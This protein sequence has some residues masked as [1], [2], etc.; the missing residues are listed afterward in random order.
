MTS[1]LC[2]LE[3]MATDRYAQSCG[4]SNG[5]LRAGIDDVGHSGHRP[6]FSP[7]FEISKSAH[8]PAMKR[9]F[10]SSIE[11]LECRIA[12]AILVNGPN[13][14]GSGNP[15]TGEMSL[16]DN[17]V[18]LVKVLAGQII[19]WY[20]DGNIASVS[21]GPG[22]NFQITG[23]VLG[24]IVGNLGADG[25]LSDSDG[26][27][28][29]GEDGNVLLPNDLAGL[30]TTQFATQ[31]GGF[32]YLITGGAAANLNISGQI[33]GIYTGDG[34]FD[35]DSDA[36]VAGSVVSSIGFDVNPLTAGPQ[37]DFTFTKA[38]SQMKAGA[39]LKN[40]VIGIGKELEVFTGSGN[41]GRAVPDPLKPGAPGGDIV[42]IT[43]KSAFLDA[44]SNGSTPSYQLKAGSGGDGKTGGKGGDIAT[45][46]EESS[47]GSV[48]FTAGNGGGGSGGKGGDGGSLRLLE[49]RSDSTRYEFHAGNGGD[50]APAGAGGSL[51]TSN[52]TN[53][54]T[55]GGII[56]TADFTG[57][58]VDDLLIVDTA[59]GNMVIMKND[60]CCLKSK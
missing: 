46:I 19:V 26:D 17:S 51:A 60:A 54:T 41:P 47:V 20:Q 49:M 6:C 32:R 5:F 23:D 30:K 50:G 9:P 11:T 2:G 10:R 59:T 34:V 18:T 29:N 12:P 33:E 4:L 28:V 39:G 24:D 40:A 43:I 37:D 44:N 55:T 13:L 45:V 53:L 27:P 3:N 21:F 31:K 1:A 38:T 58:G 57:D 56:R 25:R 7:S 36:L 14:L 35:A 22:A 15:A 8:L 16:G 52:F 42:N 48:F